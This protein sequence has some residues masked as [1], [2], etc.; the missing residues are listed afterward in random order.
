GFYRSGAEFLWLSP[1]PT[2]LFFGA[3]S[4]AGITLA[5]AV[6]LL[7]Y[8]FW[9]RSRYFGNTAP[10][11]CALSLLLLATIEPALE[12]FESVPHL[13]AFFLAKRWDAAPL[14]EGT[15]TIG[16]PS[17]WALPFLL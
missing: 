10:L 6:A 4:N 2:R 15:I 13:F 9:R 17:L 1:A 7:R 12:Y 3:G 11:L 8:L 16:A 5:F 14:F